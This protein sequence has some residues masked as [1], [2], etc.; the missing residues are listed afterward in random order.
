MTTA[1][2][3]RDYLQN[4][5]LEQFADTQLISQAADELDALTMERDKLSEDV[6]RLSEKVEKLRKR[7]LSE[8]EMQEVEDRCWPKDTKKQ[9]RVNM[10]RKL[11]EAY[12]H[13]DAD[14]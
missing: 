4:G 2:R 12:N 5:S 11:S 8:E 13:E 1:D 14:I 3:L 6:R 10:L 7:P 9:N